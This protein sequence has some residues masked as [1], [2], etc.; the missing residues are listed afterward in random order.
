VRVSRI[1]VIEPIAGRRTY[2]LSGS[3]A[4]HV[5]RVLRLQTGDPLVLFDGRGGEYATTIDALGRDRVTVA[6]GEHS[7]TDRESAVNLTLVQGVSRGERMDLIVQKATELGVTSIVPVVTSRS[8]VRTS[9]SRAE[10]KVEHWRAIAMAACEQC[11]RNRLPQIESPVAWQAWLARRPTAGVA[12]LL[13][14]RAATRLGDALTAAANIE[15]LIGPEGGLTPE[16]ETAALAAGFHAVTLG[17]RVLRT[18]TAAIAAIAAIQ[19]RIG[20][21]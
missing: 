1:H 21:L 19:H 6:V 2:D 10:R 13:A 5:A 20:D 12:L 18:E 11:G 16:E 4:N 9:E 8:V 7:A 3:A 15:L 17:P 14:T